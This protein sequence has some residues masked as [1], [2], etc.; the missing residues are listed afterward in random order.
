MTNIDLRAVQSLRLSSQ[1]E[2]KCWRIRVVVSIWFTFPTQLSQ[3]TTESLFV[4]GIGY[5][6][7]LHK[8]ATTTTLTLAANYGHTHSKPSQTWSE[9]TCFCTSDLHNKE[10]RALDSWQK[11]RAYTSWYSEQWWLKN[12]DYVTSVHWFHKITL[13]YVYRP[14]NVDSKSC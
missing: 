11:S 8:N 1:A 2:C 13:M 9:W 4:L 3:F 5:L 6:L 10:D 14:R 7:V 12:G